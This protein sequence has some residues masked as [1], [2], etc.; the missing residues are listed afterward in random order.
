MKV[1]CLGVEDAERQ[2]HWM[3]V[4]GV[5]CITKSV[6]L[7]DEDTK[8]KNIPEILEGAVRRQA[9]A[10]G[11]LIL[12][13]ERQL[14]I[15]KSKL[16]LSHTPLGCRQILTGVTQ[17]GDKSRKRAEVSAECR[18]LQA[19]TT[20][21]PTWRRSFHVTTRA[22]APEVAKA[23]EKREVKILLKARKPK[24]PVDQVKVKTYHNKRGDHSGAQPT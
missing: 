22:S 14:Q 15:E 21:H 6:P 1:Y 23:R 18:A 9:G 13:M 4:V 16:R 11:L 19:A 12:M 2:I 20:T 7:H 10:A 8:R 17:W 3:E 24:E 5:K